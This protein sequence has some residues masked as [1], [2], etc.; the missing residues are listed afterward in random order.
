MFAEDLAL[1]R[2]NKRSALT[3]KCEKKEKQGYDNPAF[4]C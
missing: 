4:T 2:C 3:W 1:A